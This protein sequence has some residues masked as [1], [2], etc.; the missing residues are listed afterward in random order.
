VYSDREIGDLLR[1]AAKLAPADGLRPR[2]YATLFGL[3]ACTGLRIA[4]APRKQHCNGSATPAPNRHDSNP[5]TDSLPSDRISDY[6]QPHDPQSPHRTRT[7]AQAAHNH[8]LGR[9]RDV[10]ACFSSS[11]VGTIVPSTSR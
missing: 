2:C 6:V 8:E 7:S 3:L 9:V 10:H 11:V 5:A 1:D 4:E